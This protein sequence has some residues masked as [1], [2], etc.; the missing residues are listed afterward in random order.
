MHFGVTLVLKR[1]YKNTDHVLF[2]VYNSLN[3][4]LFTRNGEA[5]FLQSP[6]EYG[7]LS[8]SAKRIVKPQC[9]IELAVGSRPQLHGDLKPNDAST[10]DEDRLRVSQSG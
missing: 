2:L 4:S 5:F 6:S 8:L 1:V 7:R 9:I 3:A 10:A